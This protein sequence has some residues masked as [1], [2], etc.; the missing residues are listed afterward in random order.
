MLGIIGAMQEE[1]LD[2]KNKMKDI[3][4]VNIANGLY[5]KGKLNGYP[6]VLTKSGIGKVNAAMSTTILITNFNIDK[7]IFTGVAGAINPK[8]E[9]EDFVISRDLIQHDVDATA[10]G[11]KLGEIP[12]MKTSTFKASPNLVEMTK[13]ILDTN[14]SDRT[15]FIGRILSGDQFIASQEKL[16]ALFKILKGDCVEMEGAACAQV[17]YLYNVEFVVVRIIS[18]KA[19]EEANI[20]FEKF[21][22]RAGKDTSFLI[23]KIC[24]KLKNEKQL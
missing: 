19:N 21:T 4:E 3:E 20:D 22:K 5:W 18:D 24:E 15:N 12:R 7:L 14:F 23:S 10:F 2:L 17:C 6:V 8:L 9:I 13:E 16:E 1:I 11:A